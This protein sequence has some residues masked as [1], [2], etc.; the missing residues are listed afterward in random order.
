ML[1]GPTALPALF[2]FFF[3]FNSVK[4]HVRTKRHDENIMNF[5]LWR[6]NF[7]SIIIMC[8]K[9]LKK[10]KKPSEKIIEFLSNFGCHA[11][12]PK[13]FESEGSLIRK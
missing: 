11:V 9:K 12:N 1:S 8:N 3:F 5:K 13:G 6:C 4:N 2:F 7:N 10:K